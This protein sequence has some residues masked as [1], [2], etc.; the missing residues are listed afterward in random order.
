MASSS[1][2]LLACWQL[3]CMRCF[4]TARRQVTDDHLSVRHRAG[5]WEYAATTV[6][7]PCNCLPLAHSLHTVCKPLMPGVYVLAH[8]AASGA[9]VLDAVQPAYAPQT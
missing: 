3:A 1:T 6:L 4:S 9:R 5:D 2:T 7:L 8:K